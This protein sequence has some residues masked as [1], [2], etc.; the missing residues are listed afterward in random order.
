MMWENPE[1]RQTVPIE[2]FTIGGESRINLPAVKM[3]A[4]TPGKWTLY[5]VRKKLMKGSV[6][7]SPVICN[8][9]QYT[10]PMPITVI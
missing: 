2:V 7:G 8:T 10:K 9:E 5:L 1:S 3:K 6:N 4:L